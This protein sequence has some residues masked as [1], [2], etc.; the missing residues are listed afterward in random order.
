MAKS[1]KTDD[2]AE[3]P[4]E[5]PPEVQ[6]TST[7]KP[8]EVPPEPV[9]RVASTLP[10]GERREPIGDRPIM[11]F[12]PY[13]TSERRTFLSVSIWK[14]KELVNDG[15]EPYFAYSVAVTRTYYNGGPD[16]KN[17][18]TIRAGE[19]PLAVL[20]LEKADSWIKQQR[21]GQ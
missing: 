9:I 21:N 14:S 4:V 12:G 3:L 8:P 18:S 7:E 10:N 2:V 17:S 20:L 5:Q 1:R 13:P 16:P 19:I 15:G 11:K 6:P